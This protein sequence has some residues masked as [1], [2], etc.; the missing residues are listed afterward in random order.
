MR[1]LLLLV[2]MGMVIVLLEMLEILLG[3]IGVVAHCKIWM[4]FS[5]VK[6]GIDLI[7]EHRDIGRL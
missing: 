6:V 1:L 4:G 5:G 7:L 3:L 2:L